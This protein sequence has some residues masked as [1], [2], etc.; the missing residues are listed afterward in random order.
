M[1]SS[2]YVAFLRGINVS[3]QKL[4]KMETLKTYFEMPGFSDVKTYI[5]SGNIIFNAEATDQ[6]QLTAQIEQKLEQELGYIVKTIVRSQE[7]LGKIISHNPYAGLVD[8][9][10]RKLYV[11]FLSGEPGADKL[12]ALPTK[13]GDNDELIFQNKEAYLMVAAYGETKLSNSFIEKKL[14]VTATTRNWATVNK[15]AGM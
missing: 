4:I 10:S 9:D 14:G 3:G 12:A 5:Q 6:Q 13:M 11:S 8:S 7:E 1:A 2:R 15:V